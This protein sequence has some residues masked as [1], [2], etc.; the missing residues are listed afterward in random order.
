[1][2]SASMSELSCLRLEAS[3][4]HTPKFALLKFWLQKTC[5]PVAFLPVVVWRMKRI[6]EL[7][8]EV[9]LKKKKGRKKEELTMGNA[10]HASQQFLESF[11]RVC[12]SSCT[13]CWHCGLR[14]LDGTIAPV[15]GSVTSLQLPLPTDC[16]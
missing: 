9:Y 15:S 6:T 3:G 4:G 11:T 7:Q 5:L 10:L 12:N 8:E 1:M 2:L 16:L 13:D 14:P